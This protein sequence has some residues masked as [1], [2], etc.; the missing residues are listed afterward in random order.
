MNHSECECTVPSIVLKETTFRTV[1]AKIAQ[2]L[3]SRRDIPW[4]LFV[5][6]TDQ[7][8]EQQASDAERGV[9]PPEQQNKFG[10]DYG[11]EKS[12]IIFSHGD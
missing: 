9:Q 3:S 8:Y 5:S 11:L 4:T 12:K 10:T 7:T 2:L 6:M 1:R